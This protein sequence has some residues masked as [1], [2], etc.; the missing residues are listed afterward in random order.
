MWTAVLLAHH[1]AV[2]LFCTPLL[3]MMNWHVVPMVPVWLRA[4]ACLREQ[5]LYNMEVFKHPAWCCLSDVCAASV[6]VDVLR[7]V[8]VC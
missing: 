5:A 7:L 3:T 6:S 2:K 1:V 4:C 8:G